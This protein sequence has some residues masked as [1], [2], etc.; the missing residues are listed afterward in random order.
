MNR[1]YEEFQLEDNKLVKDITSS[2]IYRINNAYEAIPIDEDDFIPADIANYMSEMYVGEFTATPYGDLLKTYEGDDSIVY[3]DDIAYTLNRLACN[4]KQFVEVVYA[5][6]LGICYDSVFETMEKNN[7]L[8]NNVYN[9][10]WDKATD[11]PEIRP[12][13]ER[14]AYLK[15]SLDNWDF[16]KFYNSLDVLEQLIVDYGTDRCE[17]FINNAKEDIKYT[18]VNSGG[19]H[20]SGETVTSDFFDK[21]IAN[22]C[23]CST[24]T[25]DFAIDM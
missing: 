4:Y 14:L 8:I 12:D 18:I 16:T 10:M 21:V 20:D 22:A 5:Q 11:C 3:V 19:V 17:D 13:F 23:N 7:I 24:G 9:A 6:E 25:C 15:L 1:K 2:R